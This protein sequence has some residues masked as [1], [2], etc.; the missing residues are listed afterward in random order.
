ARESDAIVRGRA[1]SKTSQITEDDSFLFTDY[2]VVVSEVFK[3]NT[4]A[5]IGTGKTITVTCVG[6]KIVVDNVIIKAGGNAVALLS[7]NAQDVLLFL[8]SVPE[9]EGYQ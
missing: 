6:G 1:T 4:A 8:K 2:D 5:P 7:V 3:D 9:A